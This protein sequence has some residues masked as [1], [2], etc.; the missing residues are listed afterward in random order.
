MYI[1]KEGV[2]HQEIRLII[3]IIIYIKTLYLY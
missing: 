2:S 1:L 3:I